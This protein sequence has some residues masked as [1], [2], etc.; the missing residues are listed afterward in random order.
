M[1]IRLVE[2]IQAVAPVGMRRFA[3]DVAPAIAV[4][5]SGRMEDDAYGEGAKQ[6]DRGM[7]EEDAAELPEECEES[8]DVAKVQDEEKQVNLFA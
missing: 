8:P 1:E 6:Q 5:G 2:G 4:E 3:A 7:E